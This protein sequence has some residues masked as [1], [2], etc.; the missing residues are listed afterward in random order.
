MKLDAPENFINR[1]LSWLEFNS[2]VLGQ[3]LEPQNPLLERLKFLAIVSSNLDEF[4][5]VR[6]GGLRQLAQSGS[7]GRCPAGLTPSQQLAEISTRVRAMVKKQYDCLNGDIFPA[8]A[9]H[10][11]IRLQPE[12]LDGPNAKAAERYFR[13]EVF[14]VLTPLAVEDESTF[15]RIAGLTLHLAFRLKKRGA[16]ADGA[17]R[18]GL[19]ALVP[20]PRSWPRFFPVSAADKYHFILLEDL[21][22]CFA[23][24]LFPGFEIIEGAAFRVTRNA[25]LPVDDDATDLLEAMQDVLRERKSGSLVRLEV[26]ARASQ[27]LTRRLAEILG[28]GTK[29][30][31]YRID[32]PL[33]LKPF[34]GLA[35]QMEAKDLRYPPFTPAQPPSFEE[36]TE[37]IWNVIRKR[38][39]LVQHPYESFDPVVRILEE[40]AS[41]PQVMAI[42]QSLYRT[43]ADSPIITALER[44]A[45]NGKQV[46]ALVEL[47]A[48]FDEQQNIQW[49]QRLSE[50]GAQVIYGVLGLKTHGKIMMIIR[51]E[52]GGVRRYVHLSTGN[53]H[54]KTARLYED[55]GLFTSDADFG[56]DGSNFFNAVTG[57]SEPRRWRRL[58]IAPTEMR[59]RVYEMIDREI[60][61]SSPENPGL[62]LIK[63]NSLLDT[64]VCVQLYRASRAGVRVRL[65]VR[66]IC[67]LR[68]GI[69]GI[70]EH[71]DVI[72]I[73][74]RYLEHSRILYL[75]NG[76]NEEV[77]LSSADWMSRNLDRRLEILFPVLDDEHKARLVHVLETALG[78]NQ[79]AYRLLPDGSY[80]PVKP[81]AGEPARRCQEIL[82][83]ETVE[84]AEALRLKRLAVFRPQGPGT[85]PGL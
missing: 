50:A 69:K 39:V 75:R 18:D 43:S 56:A 47:K 29:E 2:R 30:E 44:A 45:L 42:K 37:A 8:L 24:Q 23:D 60:A 5:M 36:E 32:G 66:G 53:Y 76:G 28:A 41:D 4:F 65:C 78:D 85:A 1:E 55:I 58:V 27:P 82:M 73:V 57:Y 20:L 31:L 61:R 10:G 38:D 48:R 81:A 21:V 80:Q 13:E 83:R 40:A 49:A 79:R 26:E 15:P 19:L 54:D 16:K 72:S 59:Q 25:D 33:D 11:I 70:S 17:A 7:R 63:C 3:G 12:T 84:R 67:C 71:I 52:A 14:P 46:T 9:R 22:A 6:V 77:Y 64:G 34:M 51:R 68:P 62:I 35:P 74:D